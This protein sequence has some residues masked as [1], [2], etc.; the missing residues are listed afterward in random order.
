MSFATV[1]K[2]LPQD[3]I[4]ATALSMPTMRD[5]GC[6]AVRVCR[7]RFSTP[8]CLAKQILAPE[9]IFGLAVFGE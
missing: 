5:S 9:D 7:G 8:T 2:R 4:P 3:A 1:S 6:G